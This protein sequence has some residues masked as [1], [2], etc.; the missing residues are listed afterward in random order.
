VHHQS[1]VWRPDRG[2]KPGRPSQAGPETLAGHRREWYS[3]GRGA[4]PA[5][6]RDDGLLAATLDTIVDTSTVVWVLLT[7]PVIHL[8]AG[9]DYQTCRQVLAE[10]GLAGEIAT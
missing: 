7:R 5:N 9:D 6:R 2:T 10:R 4:C 1:T 8:D 3:A